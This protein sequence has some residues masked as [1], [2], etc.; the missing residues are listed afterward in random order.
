MNKYRNKILEIMDE[1]LAAGPD[2]DPVQLVEALVGWLSEDD[3]KEFYETYY[4]EQENEDEDED[5]DEE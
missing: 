5:E 4:D 1:G 3:A 2:F